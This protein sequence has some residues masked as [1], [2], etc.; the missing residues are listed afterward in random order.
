[1]RVVGCPQLR[2]A[3]NHGIGASDRQ[4]PVAVFVETGVV[5][6]PGKGF[7][8]VDTSARVSLANLTENEYRAIGAAT[9]RIVDEYHE[10]FAHSLP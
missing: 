5:L 10:A 7:E 3:H 1:M 4:Q 6:L 9:R 2:P 8:V